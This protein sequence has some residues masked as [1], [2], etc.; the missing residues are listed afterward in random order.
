MFKPDHLLNLALPMYAHQVARG[1]FIYYNHI[2]PLQYVRAH[3]LSHP[4]VRVSCTPLD[5][6]SALALAERQKQLTPNIDS[7]VEWLSYWG[8]IS[9]PNFY[10]TGKMA[11]RA[12]TL[13]YIYPSVTLIDVCFAEGVTEAQKRGKGQLI[14]VA[15]TKITEET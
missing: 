12:P 13:Q 8:W 15:V 5:N 14:G 10:G 9:N 11:P 3:V 6:D 7:P 4:I 2:G 1:G